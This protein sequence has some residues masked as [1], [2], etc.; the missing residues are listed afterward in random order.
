MDESGG[1]G[2]QGVVDELPVEQ[3]SPQPHPSTSRELDD[4]PK[5]K[6]KQGKR[7]KEN[8][9]MQ[10]RILNLMENSNDKDEIDL[11]FTAISKHMK[12]SLNEQQQEN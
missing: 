12:R 8:E 9:E 7:K 1:A 3:A 5:P 11:A 10:Q 4:T 6:V 2:D